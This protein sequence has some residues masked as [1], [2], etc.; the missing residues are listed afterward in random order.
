MGTTNQGTS[1]SMYLCKECKAPLIEV[2]SGLACSRDWN[3]GK[4]RTGEWLPDKVRRRHAALLMGCPECQDT[5]DGRYYL[6]DGE[7]HEKVK[8]ITRPLNGKLPKLEND[9]VI[10]VDGSH[11]LIL[12]KVK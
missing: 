7:R 5:G 4:I 10:A 1:Y 9:E 2:P 11:V 3:C 6:L 12:K 8:A